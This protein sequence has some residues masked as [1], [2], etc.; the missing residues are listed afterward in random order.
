MYNK[1][2]TRL[3]G[4]FAPIFYLNCEHVHFVYILKQSRKKFR[5]FLKK[6]REFSR[7][8]NFLQKKNFKHNF[9]KFLSFVN[10]PC[11]HVMSHKKFGPD[12]FSRFDVYWIQTNKQTPKQTDKPN[13]YIDSSKLFLVNK[14]FYF[15]RLHM[16]FHRTLL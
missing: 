14:H 2:N 1:Y 12:R 4:R 13:L 6:I 10:L 5:G 3:L 9:F 7:F 16:E 15:K 8:Y 11:G